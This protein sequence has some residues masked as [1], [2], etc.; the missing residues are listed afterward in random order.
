MC[1]LAFDWR[2]DATHGHRLLVA[3][4][5]DEFHHRAARPLQFWPGHEHILAGIDDGAAADAGLPGTWMGVTRA[6]RFAALTNFRAPQERNPQASTRGR[7]VTDFL[8]S[9]LAPA[10]YLLEVQARARRYNGFNLLVGSTLGRDPQLWWYSNRSPHAP[11]RLKA[12]LYGLSNALLDTPWPKLRLAVARMLCATAA[13]SGRAALFGLLADDTPAADE[14]LPRTGLTPARERLLSS[15]FIRSA[16]YGTRCSQI[17]D[18]SATGRIDYLERSFLP[19]L[20]P[21]V[22]ESRDFSFQAVRVE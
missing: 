9:T 17:L 20:G 18:I 8:A 5:R 1:L 21:A 4:N 14:D 19:D 7:L 13:G 3:A 10:E 12:G 6:G 2:P 16:D 22:F 11:L 15:A